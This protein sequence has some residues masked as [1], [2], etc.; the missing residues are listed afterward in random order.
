MEEGFFSDTQSSW[1]DTNENISSP[2]AL[3]IY[4][5]MGKNLKFTHKVTASWA[6]DFNFCAQRISRT[7]TKMGHFC[8]WLG[9]K[10]YTDRV[11]NNELQY[12]QTWD[13]LLNL[14][15]QKILNYSKIDVPQYVIVDWWTNL[16]DFPFCL[17]HPHGSS[18]SLPTNL[19]KSLCIAQDFWTVTGLILSIINRKK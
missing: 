2:S 10:K 3:H 15:K 8:S 13:I 12:E 18:T 11:S 1:W 6:N 5:R 14:S 7:S 9:G 4:P 16:S 19:L 17:S